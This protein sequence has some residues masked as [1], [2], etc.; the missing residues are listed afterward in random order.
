MYVL[1]R[2]PSQ[3]RAQVRGV[4]KFYSVQERVAQV[5]QVAPFAQPEELFLNR[6]HCPLGTSVSLRI[7]IAGEGLCDGEYCARV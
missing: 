2:L 7:I 3:R 5:L 4:K 6:T 1:W